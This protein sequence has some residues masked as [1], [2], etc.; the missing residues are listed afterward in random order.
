MSEK[1]TKRAPRVSRRWVLA[2]FTP[3]R[4]PL[5]LGAAAMALRA[6]VVTLSPWPLKFVIDSVIYQRP[7]PHYLHHWLAGP[8]LGRIELLAILCAATV[9]LGMFDAV[10]DYAGSRIFLDVGQ[11]LVF[12][13]RHDL[14]MCLQR[15]SLDFHHKHRGGDLMSRLGGDVSKLQDL[16]TTVGGD[17]IQNA[18]VVIGTSIIMFW[19]DWKFGLA[20]LAAFPLIAIVIRSYSVLLQRAL[21]TVRRREGDLWSMAQEVLG[22]MRLVQAYGRENYEG[23]RFAAGAE[24]LFAAGR[25]ANE[26]QAQF[27]P[28]MTVSVAIATAAIT[29][30]GVSKVLAGQMTAGELLVFLSYFRALAT[31]VRR[32]GKTSRVIGR[33]SIALDRIGDYLLETP[34]VADRQGALAPRRCSGLVTFEAVDFHYTP[35]RPVL[36]KISFTLAPGKTVALIGPTGGGKS[37][38]AA[39]IPRLH[40]P[41]GGRITLDGHDLRDL[42]LAFLRAHVAMVLQESMLFNAT[43]WENICYGREGSGRD[44]A[45]AA[46]KAV[47]VHD[48]IV[49]L[50]GGYE[51]VISERGHTLSGGQRQC[52]SVAR[53]MLSKAPV[54]ILDEPSSNLDAAMESELMA[55]IG[56]LIADRSALTIAHRLRTV[57]TADEIL[58]LDRGQIL[59]RGRHEDLIGRAGL[60]ASLWRS[61]GGDLDAMVP[62]LAGL[63]SA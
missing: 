46:A 20:I 15:L 32:V 33:A 2:Y 40:D 39:L 6:V 51:L 30:Y 28:V 56:R 14:F 63:K 21:H 42:K 3:H 37:T 7:L 22:S 61:A 49:G 36:Q 29:W 27:S 26:L 16:V 48:L 60:Y 47:G 34:T 18:L 55:A 10:L 43:I 50:Q 25:R 17:F 24:T 62:S 19:V 1:T 44:D 11:K 53:A 35:G 54:V 59:Q 8:Q 45:I 13:L 12:A 52:V 38:I 58:V 57:M 9:L 31:P 23:R 41:T 4:S 5:A